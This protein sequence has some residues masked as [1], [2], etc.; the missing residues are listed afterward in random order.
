MSTKEKRYIKE[1]AYFNAMVDRCGETWWGTKTPAGKRRLQKR[2]ELIFKQIKNNSS[3]ILELGCGTG[4]ITEYA[5]AESFFRRY[6]ACDI[7][8]SA[9]KIAKEKLTNF[10][11]IDFECVNLTYLSY[12]DNAFDLIIGSSILHHVSLKDTIKEVYRVLKIGGTICFFEPNMANPQV[13]IT[14]YSFYR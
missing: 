4:A 10:S 6:L 14:E 8:F 12:K 11:K 1:Q 3:L 7:S 2:T 13:F 5:A 9:L